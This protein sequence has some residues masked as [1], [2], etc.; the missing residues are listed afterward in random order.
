MVGPFDAKSPRDFSN[1]HFTGEPA[2]KGFREQV[3]VWKAVSSCESANPS[4]FF[5]FFSLFFVVPLRQR[6][7]PTAGVLIAGQ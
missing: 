4:P 7:V 1:I 2:I 6:S 3:S 5:G